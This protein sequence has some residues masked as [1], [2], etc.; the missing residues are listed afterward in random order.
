MRSFLINSICSD[1]HILWNVYLFTVEF[2]YQ[3][4]HDAD[5]E[6]RASINGQHTNLS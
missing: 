5:K 4:I 3:F 6:S 2:L 1:V